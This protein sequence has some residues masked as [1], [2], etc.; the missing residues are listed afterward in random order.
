MSTQKKPH[1]P[2]KGHTFADLETALAKAARE[3]WATH[4]NNPDAAPDEPEPDPAVTTYGE[5]EPATFFLFLDGP[6]V[7]YLD[8]N[9]RPV[10]LGAR[11]FD[12]SAIRGYDK[13]R[14]LTPLEVAERLCPDPA[15]P[16]PTE[17]AQA[18]SHREATTGCVGA[19]AYDRSRSFPP[20]S[21]YSGPAGAWVDAVD[22]TA[23]DAV[24]ARDTKKP[25]GE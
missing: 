3:I 5:L 19:H 2:R 6:H 11:Q 10:A 12:P 16:A 8:G 22:C 24:R 23:D 1:A 14:V 20:F 9:S 17:A 25:A 4:P 13:V 21:G 18:P 15:K 7:W